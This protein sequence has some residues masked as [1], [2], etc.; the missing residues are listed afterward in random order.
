M[1]EI[2]LPGVKERRYRC[3]G[4]AGA[5]PPDLPPVLELVPADCTRE[6]VRPTV[7]AF[8]AQLPRFDYKQ[9]AAGREPGEDD[10]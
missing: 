8:R 9:A 5:A 10:E 3:T 7:A 6:I 2:R 4:C 1:L